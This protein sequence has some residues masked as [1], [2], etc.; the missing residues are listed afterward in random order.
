MVHHCVVEGHGG[1]VSLDSEPGRGTR[2]RMALPTN[3]PDDGDAS[4]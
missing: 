1:Q 2:V 4:L 3:A